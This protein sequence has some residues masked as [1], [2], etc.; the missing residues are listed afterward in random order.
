MKISSNQHAG[1]PTFLFTDVPLKIQK[2]G[3]E[4]VSRPLF[5]KKFLIKNY[6]VM[7]HNL[8]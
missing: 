3:V 2:K 8:A 1:L 4:A 6:F 7:L 5:L